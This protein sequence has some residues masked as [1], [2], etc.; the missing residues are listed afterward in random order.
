MRITC[1]DEMEQYIPA[2]ENVSMDS[3]KF[4]KPAL[5]ADG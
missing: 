4:G 2:N 5:P 3:G 1:P